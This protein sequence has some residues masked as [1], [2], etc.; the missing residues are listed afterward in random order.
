MKIGDWKV[1]SNKNIPIQVSLNEPDDYHWHVLQ[2]QLPHVMTGLLDLLHKG[3]TQVKSI[4][5][6]DVVQFFLPSFLTLILKKSNHGLSQ[7]E[8]L[9]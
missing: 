7:D 1:M 3:E 9:S 4:S 6:L 8:L 5:A 2:K